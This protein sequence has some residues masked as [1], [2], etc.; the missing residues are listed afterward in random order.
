MTSIKVC[1]CLIIFS[2]SPLQVWADCP[3]V[4]GLDPHE[5][6]DN[7]SSAGCFL[8][9]PEGAAVK[10]KRKDNKS[11]FLSYHIGPDDSVRCGL[12]RKLEEDTGLTVNVGKVLHTFHPSW[13]AKSRLIYIFECKLRSPEDKPK[14]RPTFNPK[15]I[16]IAIVNPDTM[17]DR[18]GERYE[19][20][21]LEPDWKLLKMLY[22]NYKTNSK[23]ESDS[24]D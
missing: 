16:K 6:F 23:T 1:L 13:G 8:A 19:W 14:G 20:K 17:E 21:F 4:P 24:S 11:R 12:S 15:G 7:F 22:R 5:K 2:L 10:I 3:V 18:W 9:F